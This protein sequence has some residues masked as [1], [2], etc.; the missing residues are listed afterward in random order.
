MRV[1][2]LLR[3]KKR[4][5]VTAGAETSLKH[6]MRLL[7]DNKISCLPVCGDSQKLIGIISDKDIFRKAYELDC[8]FQDLTVGDC[9]TDDVIVGLV[10][11]EVAYIAGVMTQNRIRH[12]PIVDGE[13]IVGL[14]SVG[15][16]VKTQ[17]ENIK[18]ENRYLRLYI[19]GGYPG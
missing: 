17:I 11:D 13:T 6:A 16:I 15:D 10:D 1:K 2:D 9:M 5:L 8:A 14:I 7:I 4:E 18:I 19:D 3:A 12:V